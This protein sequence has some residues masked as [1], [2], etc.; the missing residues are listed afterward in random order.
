MRGL[1][2]TLYAGVFLALLGLG[3]G[4]DRYYD[5]LLEDEKTLPYPG[6]HAALTLASNHIYS[7]ID[8]PEAARDYLSTQAL[9]LSLQLSLEP[10]NAIPLPTALSTLRDQGEIIMLE[11]ETGISLHQRIQASSWILSLELPSQGSATEQ[12]TR[13]WLTLLFYLGVAAILL[14]WLTPLLRGIHQLT[15]AAKQIGQGALDTRVENPDGI[16]LRP[17]KTQ[18][19]AMAERLQRLNE[20]NRLLSQAVSHEL[21]TPLSRLRFA[22]DLLES[23]IDP[24]QRSA[25]MKR[26]ESDLDAMEALINELL[27]YA[28]LDSNSELALTFQNTAIEQLIQ[29]RIEQRY[30]KNCLIKFEPSQ[31]DSKLSIDPNYLSKV[32]DNLIQN[33]CRHSKSQVLI[34]T[35]W[36]DKSF[37]MLISDDG[38]GI[39]LDQQKA[40]FKP[41]VRIAN[42]DDKQPRGFGLGLAIVQRIV[43]WHLGTIEVSTS[44]RLGGA[45]FSIS[46]PRHQSNSP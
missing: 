19:N 13:F 9:E 25:D 29:A 44:E 33:A 37:E 2:F 10:V 15:Q 28:R 42:H 8:N 39:P 1:I 17:L 18:F 31:L 35:N 30:E 23:R 3:W 26:M 46:L 14:L 40:I 34:Q 45:L 12:Q 11:S 4:I 5:S 24:Q 38:A 43:N 32:I 7:L 36:S 16:Y 41:F 6:Y 21:R 20:N 27:N 22:L